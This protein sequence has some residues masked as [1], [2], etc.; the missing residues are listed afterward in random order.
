[1]RP[2]LHQRLIALHVSLATDCG[3]RESGPANS[4]IKFTLN[5]FAAAA[6]FALGLAFFLVTPA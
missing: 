6:I 5:F 1:M 3:R 4:G 2:T